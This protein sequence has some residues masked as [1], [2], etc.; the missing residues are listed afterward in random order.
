MPAVLLAETAAQAAGALWASTLAS[1]APRRFALAQIVQF[2]VLAPV[3]PGTTVESDVVLDHVL[4][5]LAQF[6]VTQRVGAEEVARGRL[7]LGKM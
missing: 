4:G 5:G 2:K 6:S 3:R 1:D 7:V